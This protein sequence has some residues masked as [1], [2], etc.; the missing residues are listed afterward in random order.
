MTFEEYLATLSPSPTATWLLDETTGPSADDAVGTI[1]GTYTNGVSLN[2][3]DNPPGMAGVSAD[4]TAASSHYVAIPGTSTVVNQSTFS[5][6]IWFKP[7]SS[8]GDLITKGDTDQYSWRVGWDGSVTQW[9]S[10]GATYR[11][12]SP[13]SASK[14]VT[15]GEWNMLVVEFSTAETKVYVNGEL[16]GSSTDTSG[17]W[18]TNTTSDIQISGRADGGGG[19]YFD[20]KVARVDYIPGTYTASEIK[21]L[22]QAGADDGS[23][24]WYAEDATR[25]VGYWRFGEPTGDELITNGTFDSDIS[26][27][28]TIG[29]IVQWSSSDG[30]TLRINRNGAGY[31]EHGAKQGISTVVGERYRVSVDV[32][33]ATFYSQVRVLAGDPGTNWSGV[34]NL[35]SAAFTTNGQTGTLTATF[36]ATGTTT[37]IIM[38]VA[39]SLFAES[40]FDNVTVTHLAS[41]EVGTSHLD[42][43]GNPT[44]NEPSLVATESDTAVTFNGT[45]QYVDAAHKL[46]ALIDGASAATV[47]FWAN[48]N[49]L[50]SRFQQV[51]KV[52]VGNKDGIGIVLRDPNEGL[53]YIGGRSQNS[54]AY[55]SLE[56]T[57]SITAGNT[58]FFAC[59]FDYANGEVIVYIDGAEAGSDDTM[60]WGST[61]YVHTDTGT[62]DTIGTTLSLSGRDMDGTLDEFAIYDYALSSAEISEMYARSD[63]GSYFWKAKNDLDPVAYWRLGES[64]GPTA[65]DEL[66]NYD[67]AY[68]DSPTLGQDSLLPSSDDTSVEFNGSS[69]FAMRTG[70]DFRP[71]DA[72][73]SISAWFRYASLGGSLVCLGDN[74]GTF[75]KRLQIGLDRTTQIPYLI[76]DCDTAGFTNRIDGP[77]APSANETHHMVVTSNGSDYR[78]YLDGQELT[79]SVSEGAD[80]GKWLSSITGTKDRVTLGAVWVSSSA[81]GHLDGN[82]DEVSIYDYALSPTDVADLWARG[83]I[84]EE[85][86]IPV[87]A[88]GVTPQTPQ[89]D[90]SESDTETANLPTQSISITTQPPEAVVTN[91]ADI[92]AESISISAQNPEISV[93]V[94]KPTPPVILS[95]DARNDN[96]LWVAPFAEANVYESIGTYENTFSEFNTPS[97]FTHPEGNAW[98]NGSL[99]DNGWFDVADY[100]NLSTVIRFIPKANNINGF[101][102]GA[103]ASGNNRWYAFQTGT[104]NLVFSAGGSNAWGT[105]SAPVLV[106]QVNTL[107]YVKSG[108]TVTA[109]LNGAQVATT[110]GIS[111]STGSGD[112]LGIMCD[113]QGNGS[114]EYNGYMLFMGMYA[115]AFD[116]TDAQSW[117]DNPY[118]TLQESFNN[119]SDAPASSVA[120]TA[121]AGT[122]ETSD[123]NQVT[124]DV[125]NIPMITSLMTATASEP[126]EKSVY[127]KL[128]T[129]IFTHRNYNLL[130]LEEQV[131]SSDLT[132]NTSNCCDCVAKAPSIIH[133]DSD[134]SVV[135]TGDEYFIDSQAMFINTQTELSVSLWFQPDTNGGTTGSFDTDG[136]GLVCCNNSSDVFANF[137]IVWFNSRIHVRVA[138]QDYTS[139]NTYTVGEPHLVNVIWDDTNGTFYLNVDGVQDTLTTSVFY[140]SFSD[141]SSVVIGRRTPTANGFRGKIQ[142]IGVATDFTERNS[143]GYH[144]PRHNAWLWANGADIATPLNYHLKSYWNSNDTDYLNPFVYFPMN[145]SSGTPADATGNHSDWWTVNTGSLTW[146]ESVD[147]EGYSDTCMSMPNTSETKITMSPKMFINSNV[148][149]DYFGDNLYSSFSFWFRINEVGREGTVEIEFPLIEFSRYGENNNF[150]IQFRLNYANDLKLFA[151]NEYYGSEPLDIGVWNHLEFRTW[152]QQITLTGLMW[153][154]NGELAFNNSFSNGF[155]YGGE[156]LDIIIKNSNFNSS[157]EKV[158]CSVD[159][160]NFAM[161]YRTS[162]FLND[163]SSYLQRFRELYQLEGINYDYINNLDNTF[164]EVIFDCQT[165]NGTFVPYGDYLTFFNDYGSMSVT[166]NNS[167]TYRQTNGPIPGMPYTIGL[168][169]SAGEGLTI[170]NNSDTVPYRLNL[171]FKVDSWVGTDDSPIVSIIDTVN[172]GRNVYV[173]RDSSQTNQIRLR[174]EQDSQTGTS[175]DITLGQWNL[176]TVGH[177]GT[178]DPTLYFNG[179]DHSLT[180]TFTQTCGREKVVI[181]NES[182]DTHGWDGDVA[183][184]VLAQPSLAVHDSAYIEAYATDKLQRE[185]AKTGVVYADP[186]TS[187]FTFEFYPIISFTGYNGSWNGTP[188]LRNE[189]SPVYPAGPNIVRLD[190]DGDSYT[191]DPIATGD[192]FNHIECYIKINSWIDADAYIMGM[193][194][195]GASADWD[196]GIKRDGSTGNIQVF[197]HNIGGTLLE[198]TSVGITTGVWHHVALVY[199]EDA[200]FNQYLEL[201]IDG[202]RVAVLQDWWRDPGFLG[203]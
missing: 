83:G 149:D 84:S 36:T 48:F 73:G 105:A 74:I 176:L 114:Q 165:A 185:W 181:G 146:N 69:E 58:Y 161:G 101:L 171:W 65:T 168:D 139:A 113:F 197:Y 198:G 9:T 156:I 145:D 120:L 191:I 46:G 79:T 85:S 102:M 135:F 164:N 154:L 87:Q 152:D 98:H 188:L 57:P 131:Q 127:S 193:G 47:C 72:Q 133:Q 3:A 150:N 112:I 51:L 96:A 95:D 175:F 5:I 162:K 32:V 21:D 30:G 107:V 106:N 82:L 136:E 45:T 140:S 38:I 49:T 186:F 103:R 182:S 144:Y 148:G 35:T 174:T 11:S 39:N 177:D 7:D 134:E 187:D 195:N 203:K 158:S 159:F 50:D 26:S 138:N 132:F 147:I 199:A 117:H 123:N 118:S 178:A 78:M 128:W 160:M 22:Y 92:P 53:S 137:G 10:L 184:I 183:L 28:G 202:V 180:H 194:E 124:G 104:N 116:L 100:T 75:W 61:T 115:E 15:V 76:A 66:G 189:A 170:E 155:N 192:A 31:N 77:S 17:T 190:S 56:F 13:T 60:T 97:S 54:D 64:T 16:G 19:G 108:T 196:I 52:D 43:K 119:A 88:I 2:N 1:D 93:S 62:I 40:R 166:P 29:G 8:S 23:Y 86:N 121:V 67:L 109:Y 14:P 179:V 70:T 125:A 110:S 111:F 80:D 167:P 34:T 6:I 18:A 153:Y 12:F 20:G 142:H 68:Q 163:E 37:W 33:A 99:A 71:S 90:T 173:E 27:W 24:F 89:A 25:P 59:V 141:N 41:D 81:A 91:D 126:P 143:D 200:S 172:S 94:V 122:F 63:D 151:E 130:E 129:K 201:Y 55:D 169:T 157:G 4:F 42:Y 44:L